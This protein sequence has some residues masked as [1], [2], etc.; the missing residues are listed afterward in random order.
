MTRLIVMLARRSLCGFS[1]SLQASMALKQQ[2]YH[3]QDPDN[4][5]VENLKFKPVDL[6]SE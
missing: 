3:V 2:H 1:F 5:E 6:E 4:V